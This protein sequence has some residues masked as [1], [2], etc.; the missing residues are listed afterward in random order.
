[1]CQGSHMCQVPAGCPCPH[2]GWHE[3][4]AETCLQAGSPPG[5]PRLYPNGQE[6]LLHQQGVPFRTGISSLKKGP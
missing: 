6:L 4:W 1:M 2:W 3:A 5:L